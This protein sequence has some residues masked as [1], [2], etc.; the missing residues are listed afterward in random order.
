M[1]NSQ[2]QP[3][4]TRILFPTTLLL[5][6]FGATSAQGA[7]LFSTGFE[8]ESLGNLPGQDGWSVSIGTAAGFQVQSSFVNTGT[9]ALQLNPAGQTNGVAIRRSVP[10][11]GQTQVYLS[12]DF[13][14]A[15]NGNPTQFRMF[16]HDNSGNPFAQYVIQDNGLTGL[17]DNQGTTIS[18]PQLSLGT[19]NNIRLQVDFSARTVDGYLNGVGIGT[20]PLLPN[21]GTSVGRVG[22]LMFP[23]T[24]GTRLAFAD[25]VE[26]GSIP[27]P[28]S[29]ALVAA[30]LAAVGLRLRRKR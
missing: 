6:A 10:G 8:T 17:F 25:N 23:G 27:E 24:T 16:L 30:G 15:L 14:V 29:M 9:Q 26:F 2:Y 28:S 13:F 12:S 19:W 5:L 7:V 11:S 1:I 22:F 21:V 4:F 3:V 18:G 20:L